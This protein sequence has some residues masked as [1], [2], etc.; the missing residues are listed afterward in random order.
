MYRCTLLSGFFLS[1]LS[2]Q[3]SNTHPQFH[4]LKF[5]RSW[6]FWVFLDVLLLLPSSSAIFLG[7]VMAL[8]TQEFSKRTCL[9]HTWLQHAGAHWVLLQH[10]ATHECVGRHREVLLGAMASMLLAAGAPSE[11]E[12]QRQVWLVDICD[13]TYWYVLRGSLMCVMWLIDMCDMTHSYMWHDAFIYLE[14]VA[15]GGRAVGSRGTTPG[16]THWYVCGD[17]LTCVTWLIDMYDVTHCYVWRDSLICAM[18][19]IR[20]CDMTH[21]YVWSMLLVAGAQSQAKAQRQARNSQKSWQ[22][23]IRFFKTK[24]KTQL[25]TE[26]SIHQNSSIW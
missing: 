9:S 26:V 17:S 22:N 15:R 20:T 7:D 1:Y 3:L 12:A 25:T 14:N 2:N 19:L 13:V 21:S 4:G 6:N 11:A 10:T 8:K 24:Q 23:L 16:M 5:S 18:W